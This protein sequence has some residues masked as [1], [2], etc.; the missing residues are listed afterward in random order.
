MRIGIADEATRRRAVDALVCSPPGRVVKVGTTHE[1]TLKDNAVSIQRVRKVAP[2]EAKAYGSA[3]R[4][5]K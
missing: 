1:V 2:V 5:A 3:P 4:V